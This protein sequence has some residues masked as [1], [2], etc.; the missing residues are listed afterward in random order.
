MDQLCSFSEA[1]RL[2]LMFLC[3]LLR[4][5][6]SNKADVH[7]MPRIDGLLDKLGIAKCFSTFDIAA[8]YWQ[9]KV[10]SCSEEKTAFI[11]HQGLYEFKVIYFG[12]MDAL[13]V[14]QRLIQIKCF[15]K[16]D[17]RSRGFCGSLSR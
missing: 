7:P 10:Q 6:C 13:A 11:T 14:F 5:E 17:D 15:I 2:Q 3:W 9:I 1:K 4:L 8:G 12:V 16:A